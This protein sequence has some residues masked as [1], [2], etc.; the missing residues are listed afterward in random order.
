LVYPF[1][2][3]SPHHHSWRRKILKDEIVLPSEIYFA[4]EKKK[5]RNSKKNPHLS[6]TLKSTTT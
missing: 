3:T 2:A 1:H 5:K 6:F 4:N